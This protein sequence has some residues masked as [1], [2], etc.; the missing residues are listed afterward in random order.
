[1]RTLA[2]RKRTTRLSRLLQYLGAATLLIVGLTALRGAIAGVSEYFIYTLPIIGGLLKSLELMEVTN[3]VVF[4]LLGLGLGAITLWL[5]QPSRLAAKAI[6]PILGVPIVFLS[7]YSVRHHL[8]IQQVALTSELLPVQARQVTDSLLLET[9]GERGLWGFFQYTVQAPILPTDLS[10]L[11]TVDDDDKWFRSEL[12]R[13]S[14]L[15]PGLFTH[16]FH[17]TGWGIRLFHLL[18]AVVTA[19]IYFTKGLVWVHTKHHTERQG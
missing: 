15:E 10:A 3:V 12:T 8:W 4:A 1:M 17:L 18:L 2:R 16:L 7:G 9:T 13:F 6:A 5:P 11:Q 19:V 14:G